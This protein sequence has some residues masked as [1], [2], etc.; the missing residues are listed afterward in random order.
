MSSLLQPEVV[1]LTLQRKLKEMKRHMEKKD[2]SE[3]IKYVV[4]LNTCY[5]LRSSVTHTPSHVCVT[6]IDC[7]IFAY[8][9]SGKRDSSRCFALI[10]FWVTDRK[11]EKR[12]KHKLE[13]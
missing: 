1:D 5:N 4:T 6:A 3:D 8:S 11:I 13:I 10:D 2:G 12:K 7:C 9:S